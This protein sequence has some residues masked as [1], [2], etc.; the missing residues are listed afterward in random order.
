MDVFWNKAV[1]DGIHIVLDGGIMIY[2]L[3]PEVSVYST[4][5][6]GKG[7]FYLLLSPIG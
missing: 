6:V 1:F 2:G 4:E 7:L 3:L 5:T